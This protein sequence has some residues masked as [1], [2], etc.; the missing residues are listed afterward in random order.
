MNQPS[1]AFQ[2]ST[3][4]PMVFVWIRQRMKSSFA[5]AVPNRPQSS[6]MPP[7]TEFLMMQSSNTLPQ[8]KKPLCSLQE[9]TV[10]DFRFPSNFSLAK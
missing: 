7:D 8:S 6:P 4:T 9:K 2:L 5:N 10:S 1:S 3:D